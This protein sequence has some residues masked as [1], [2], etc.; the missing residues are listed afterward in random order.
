MS[1]LRKW[2]WITALFAAAVLV[3]TQ[4]SAALPQGG[5]AQGQKPPAP[6]ATPAQQGSS[7]QDSGSVA[8][9][10]RKAKAKKEKPAS[11]K[12][13][14]DDDLSSIKGDGVSVVG[15]ESAVVEDKSGADKPANATQAKA[16]VKDEAYWRARAKQ[17]RDQLDAVDQ[18]IAKTEDDIKKGGG[19]GFDPQTG[20]TQSVVY[21][22][23]RNTKLKKLQEKKAALQKQMDDLEDEAR[24]ENVPSGWLR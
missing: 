13:I 12:V 9:A 15:D 19:A 5:Q 17:I 1:N 16:G 8:D 3:F 24:R 11:K 2:P 10:A 22:E 21:F 7:S 20:L 6:D 4:G 23:D 14:T 18:Q